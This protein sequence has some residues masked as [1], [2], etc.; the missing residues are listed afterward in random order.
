MMRNAIARFLSILMRPIEA[1]EDYFDPD[2]K[3]DV[4]F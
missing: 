1:I 3:L 2:W 4:E